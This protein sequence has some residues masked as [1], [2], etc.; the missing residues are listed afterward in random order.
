MH[1]PASQRAV[2]FARLH[3]L[4]QVPQFEESSAKVTSQPSL[5]SP[6]QSARPVAQLTMMQAP[7][8]Q[9]DVAPALEHWPHPASE[10]SVSPPSNGASVSAASGAL[11]SASPLVSGAASAEPAEPAIVPPVPPLPLEPADP[12]LP[13]LPPLPDSPSPPPSLVP[14]LPDLPPAGAWSSDPHAFTETDRIRTRTR[15]A[16]SF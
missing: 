11:L 2:A 7:A 5:A 4:P 16:P 12:P 10:P 13:E 9:R 8:T 14:A 6:L 1:T 15:L 3:A